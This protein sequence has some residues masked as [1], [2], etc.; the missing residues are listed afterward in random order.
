MVAEFLAWWNV[1]KSSLMIGRMPDQLGPDNSRE[2]S[3]RNA[4][5]EVHSVSR[6]C[7]CVYVCEL[8]PRAGNCC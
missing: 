5:S 1:L 6:V 8:R 3:L 4:S 2:K 7:A